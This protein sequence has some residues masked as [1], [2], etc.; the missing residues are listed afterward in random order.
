MKANGFNP[1]DELAHI[2]IP[3]S[4]TSPTVQLVPDKQYLLIKGRS[5]Q[6][7]PLML[8]NR[9]K[10]ALD[11]Y[12]MLRKKNLL[13]Y[14]KLE[15]FNTSSAKCIYNLLKRIQHIS[16]RGMTIQINWYYEFDDEDM[17]EFG[18]DFQDAFRMK[19]NMIPC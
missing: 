13:V 14:I 1:Y 8:Y 18:T 3:G 15:Y 9:I 2:N 11:K 5:C 12:T 6:E 17:L 16:S 19:F 7:N 4:K 10:Y